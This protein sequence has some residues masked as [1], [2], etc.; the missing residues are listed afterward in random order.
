MAKSNTVLGDV[1][2][3]MLEKRLL[4]S[5]TKGTYLLPGTETTVRGKDAAV[6]ALVEAAESADA[7]ATTSNALAQALIAQKVHDL[8]DKGRTQIQIASE[9]NMDITHVGD[10]LR[11]A[12]A[13]P[14]IWSDEAEL[15]KKVVADRDKSKTSWAG[16]AIR[17]GVSKGTI[18]RLY[19]E[20]GKDPHKSDIGKGGRRKDTY[21]SGSKAPAKTTKP[22]DKK[23]AGK[24]PVGKKPVAG[25]TG[26]K[27]P[28]S[29]PVS[30]ST[31]KSAGKSE[32]TPF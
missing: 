32:D 30:K 6:K 17:A 12:A 23:P 5:G 27:K 13:D 19:K 22:A 29:K 20:A 24:K 11:W 3:S 25:K 14:I 2:Q 4:P 9:V 28:V 7:T 26:V 16:I 31:G 15:Q 21:S 18:Q 10:L 1:A 8:A